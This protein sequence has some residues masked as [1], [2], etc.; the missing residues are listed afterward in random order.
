MSQNTYEIAIIGGG[1][2]GTA[3]L[4]TLSNYTNVDRIALIEKNSAV[5]LVNSCKSNNSQT[6]HFGDIETNYT[7][8]KARKVNRAAT[9]VK[10]YLLNNDSQQQ[11]YTKYH[12][13]VLAVGE[14]QVAKLKNRYE[15]FKQLFPTLKLIDKEKIAE[16]EPKILE[17]RETTEDIL[18]LFTEEGYTINFQNLSQLFLGHAIN[19]ISK[20]ID[21][22]FDHQVT[23]ITKQDDIYVIKTPEKTIRAKAIAVEAGAHSLLLAK[24]LGYGRDY[25]LLS[26]AGSFYFAPKMLKGKVYTVQ[27]K[28][29]PFAA[30]HG[31]PEVD[32]PDLT[33][34]GPTAK[35]LPMLER[36]NYATVLEYFQTAGLRVKAIASFLKILSDF[37]VLRYIILNL[38]YDLPVIGKRLFIKQVRK[39]I[40]SITLKDLKFARGYG[41]VRPQIVNLNTRSLEL[42][43]AKILGD[44][45]LF[46]ITPSPGASTCLQNAQDD[47]ESLIGFLG[48]GYKFNKEKFVA[49]LSNQLD[50]VGR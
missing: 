25:A 16:L 36:R 49:D 38:I 39:I 1:V 11:A 6:L 31:D 4:Y 13:M 20:N 50:F 32:N 22:F 15:E 48:K 28:K 10:N 7:L 9:L 21:I 47:T 41:G 37:T 45:I 18:A 17:E 29:L 12:K 26:V 14:E 19:K 27:L 30:I 46:N 24:S 44:N 40:P 34:F 8:E 35:V 5:A 2:C 23:K 3:L 33:R 42:G 43:E